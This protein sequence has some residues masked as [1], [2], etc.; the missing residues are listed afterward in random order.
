[1]VI[2]LNAKFK[3]GFVDGTPKTPSAKDKPEEYK[4]WKKMQQYSIILDL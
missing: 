3:L 1:M 2:S 4:A